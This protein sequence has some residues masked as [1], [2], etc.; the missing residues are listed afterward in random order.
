MKRLCALVLAIVMVMSVASFEV[1]ADVKQTITAK[2]VAVEIVDET[3]FDVE[4]NLEDNQGINLISMNVSWDKDKFTIIGTEFPDEVII[5]DNGTANVTDPEEYDIDSG[6]LVLS[7][8]SDIAKKNY[9][10]D[11]TL[12]TLKF[13]AAETIEP[14]AYNINLS[15]DYDDAITNVSGNAVPTEL[16]NA[17]ITLY[18]ILNS[19]DISLAA[20]TKNGTPQTTVTGTGY[21]GNV[22]WSPVITN[23]KFA[24]NM[25]YTAEVVLN[26]TTGYQFGENFAVDGYTVSN[27]D[28]S[29][30]TLTKTFAKTEDKV[31]TGIV[32][33]TAPT[34][35]AYEH[36]DTL[37]TA[38][39]VVTASYDDDSSA[40]VTDY[41]VSY[42][43]GNYLKKGDTTAKVTFDGKEATVTDL[44]VGTKK[45]TV[46]GLT[47]TNRT[48]NG[49]N[50]VVLT[51]GEISDVAEGENV[52]ATFPTSG[53]VADANAETGKAVTY[54]PITLSGADADNYTVEQ[55]TITVDI[56]KAELTADMFDIT[57]PEDKTYDGNTIAITVP[58]LKTSYASDG[59]QLSVFVNGVQESAVPADAGTY[60]I[61]FDSPDGGA[62]FNSTDKK[63]TI[64][65][66]TIAP[67]D[68][69]ITGLSAE[70][71]T[72]DGN[73]AA[74]VAGT[75][76][77]NGKLE[78][79]NVTVSAGTAAFADAYVG[80]GKTVTFTGYS[81]TGEK[82][83]NYNLTAQPANTTAD[84]TAA[85]Q[86]PTITETASLAKG[87]NT[88]DL[89]TLVSGAEGEVS[90]EIK[91]GTAATLSGTT[92][93]STADTGDVVVKVNVAAKDENGDNK[94][95]YNA[96]TTANDITITVVDKSEAN[97][98]IV[99]DASITK[100]YGDTSF[101][102]TADAENKGDSNRT[103]NWT[104]NNTAVATVA[105]G[106]V[107]IK[108]QGSAVITAK[109]ESNNTIGEASVALTVNKASLTVT[110]NA[111]SI[112]YGESPAGNGV[113]Y[114]GFVN[115]DTATVV[116]GTVGY[117]YNYAQYGDVGTYEI[118]PNG[119]NAANYDITYA[120]GALT[121]TAKEVGLSW[122]ESTFTYDGTSKAPS[123]EATGLVNGDTVTV[124][125]TGGQTDA[126]TYTA[127]ASAISGKNYVLP[128]AKTKSFTINKAA[129]SVNTAPVAAQNLAYNGNAQA[130]ATAGTAT[131]G[132]IVYSLTEA[133]NYSKT[134]PT[135]TYAG[136]YT[137]YYK[138]AG[139]KNHNDTAPASVTAT[140]G[141]AN[142]TPTIT[143]TASLAKGGNTLDLSALVSGA[144]GTVS[145]EIKSGTAATL[146]G[147]TLTSTANTGDVVITVNITAKNVNN[148]GANEYNAYTGDGAI[149]VTVVDKTEANVTI[150]GEASIT[151]TYGD[152]S[153][154]LTA[155]AEHKGDSNRT[156]NWTSNNTAVATVADG[157][158]T[159]VGQGSATITAKFES[160]NTIG[161]ASVT[162]TVNK[163]DV[164]ITG[165]AAANKVYD[166]NTTATITGTAAVDGKVG[167]DNVSVVMGSAAFADKNAAN[168][169][170]VNFTGFSLT[171]DKAAN[172]NL[173]AQPASVTADITPKAVTITGVTAADKV[174][175]GT[176]AAVITGTHTVDGV[177]GEDDVTVNVGT[178]SFD[179]ANAKSEKTVTFTDFTL[180]GADKDNYVLSAQ[181]A[182]VKAN[183]T[184][185]DRDLSVDK[186]SIL[187]YPGANSDSVTA[188][189]EKDLDKSAVVSYEFDNDIAS[190]SFRDNVL[191]IEGVIDGKATLTF[192][193]AATENYNAAADKTVSVRVVKEPASNVYAVA[194]DTDVD[195]VTAQIEGEVI[196]INGIA[197]DPN[198][199]TL[200]V[201]IDEDIFEQ[202]VDG[203]TVTIKLKGSDTVVKT[204]KIDK[205][206]VVTKA[207][208]V[209]IAGVS[210]VIQ[211]DDSSLSGIAFGDET[212]AEN[213]AAAA[214]KELND[215]AAKNMTEGVTNVEVELTVTIAPKSYNNGNKKMLIDVTPSY[216]VK[217]TNADGTTEKESVELKE[218][219]GKI[220]I[221]VKLPDGFLP[222]VA[223]LI[224]SARDFEF[225]PVSVA[226]G[227]ASWDQNRFSDV[228]LIEGK[229]VSISYTFFNETEKTVP[230]KMTDI[231]SEL[232]IDERS[233]YTFNGWAITADGEEL[234]GK[235]KTL[236][237]ELFNTLSAA[238]EITA[239]PDFS[240]IY[241]GGSYVALA[242][243]VEVK[244]SENGRVSVDKDTAKSG[245]TVALTINPADG[246]ILK[247]LSVK[248]KDGN[249]VAVTRSLMTAK[250][251]MPDGKVTVEAEFEKAPEFVDVVSG[252]F[253]EKA[254]DWAV[255]N[256]ITNGV[257]ATHFAPDASCTRAQAVTFLW[258]ALGCPEPKAAKSEFAD[259]TDADAFYYKAVL[260]AAENGVTLGYDDGRF[261]VDDT[262]N[263][264]QMVTFMER[265]MNGEATTAESFVDVPE[266]AYYA[267]AA[268]WAKENGV[269]E[270]IG[271]GK[272]GGE[273]DCL[274]AQIVTMLYRYFV[275]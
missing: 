47:A 154:T 42:S 173:K 135:G 75:A 242:K 226:N 210:D 256:G 95:E 37:N 228:E 73:T 188:K 157:V 131:G 24:A 192:K 190:V 207:E 262:V 61:N 9:T 142:Q 36:G 253:Y 182:S 1:F 91:S 159:I 178:A 155:D 184:K 165:L 49:T 233:G 236:T 53:T 52:T 114:T 203:D 266:G 144:E 44:T 145:F 223:K 199:V 34:K 186:E 168:G 257:D 60:T 147:S 275:K 7:L 118:T 176:V 30:V 187:L 59:L 43:N 171:G 229:S 216:V 204:Y 221:S 138:V 15:V 166:G 87:G 86:N 177:I 119:L 8:G 96:Y 193:V 113:S 219:T 238:S 25:A 33:T 58:T 174:Y 35:T 12:C 125:V 84:I 122:G 48:Y 55:P 206:G 67:K 45:L 104:S 231:G 195:E 268:A 63:M 264:G 218:I 224:H 72:Y 261:G 10:G 167:S 133:G 123:A 170:T 64:G 88:L 239:E 272:F 23:N 103:W 81:L 260:W 172:Y 5:P 249:E 82:S 98:T 140:I 99:G 180:G 201:T 106:V 18:S 62:N 79:D 14:G 240:V 128:S 83:G 116:T 51:G 100:T 124:T 41:T 20:P 265:A 19:A 200:K 107:T 251:T 141:A 57:A 130:L 250:F 71:K 211:P 181:P 101:T 212:K 56:S 252:S 197:K 235:F 132:D 254:V 74:T 217:I 68:V 54:A 273:T 92:L 97:V 111:N 109:F 214:A 40:A 32:V 175:D 259:V 244:V 241:S 94:V 93:T 17:T 22:S 258:R 3:I 90:F 89:R 80:T 248:D 215:I 202:T 6:L 39:M 213:V 148:D 243:T 66:V 121:V 263:R 247:S 112:V 38:G 139:D 29:S 11:G 270:G 27:K 151:K 28:A 13:K 183:I 179:D 150:D 129:S 16:K 191:A 50:S 232:E 227:V 110:A 4:I 117:T 220:K 162:L 134:I 194:A 209:N 76:V 26:A 70:N 153:F 105:D 136:S 169:K 196:K 230:Y 185:A 245:D 222:T 137:V 126:G 271:E 85:N 143:A 158:V 160:N 46:T 189:V 127:T 78:N 161:E 237:E 164:T 246:Y 198:A 234:D 120:K 21:T 149:T 208:D 65:T 255:L 146:E 108:G 77:I 269:S 205:S 225:V 2:S 274:R 115:G 267:D 152:A 156:W 69:T 31:I 102:L 163:K